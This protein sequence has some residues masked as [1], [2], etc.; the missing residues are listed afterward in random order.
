M[1]QEV[2]RLHR[3]KQEVEQRIAELM[4]FYSKQTINSNPSSAHYSSSTAGRGSALSYTHNY[5]QRGL[6]SGPP[7]MLALSSEPTYMPQSK[8]DD[9]AADVGF[10]V[11]AVAFEK[12]SDIPGL[13]GRRSHY[14]AYLQPPSS[15]LDSRLQSTATLRSYQ[16]NVNGIGG[17]GGAG[18]GAAGVHS[19]MKPVMDLRMKPLRSGRAAAMGGPGSA[20]NPSGTPTPS[21]SRGGR[22]RGAYH[23]PSQLGARATPLP[24][25]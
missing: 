18:P 17:V 14:Q 1:A 12:G 9:A 21:G 20:L 4:A 8:V 16:G 2:E 25:N 13:S 10:E 11:D 24:R 6:G 7:G 15:S 22:G 3:D 19:N 23:R 5:T